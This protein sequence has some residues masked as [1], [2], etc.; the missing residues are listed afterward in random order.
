MNA[1]SIRTP[2]A[3]AIRAML[4]DL[5]DILVDAVE[6][7]AGVSFMAPLDPAEAR[8]FWMSVSDDV[9]AGTK[10]LLVAD[11]DGRPAGTVLLQL[12]WQPNQPHR[13]EV[14]KLL[15]HRRARRLGLARQ[16]MRALEQEARARR[17]TLLV[18]DT[19]SGGAAEQLY[20]ALG[21]TEVGRIP[22]Y[23]LMP[24]GEM[25]DTTYFYRAL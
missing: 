25:S 23:A 24:Y 2:D 17:R 11:H 12:M 13:A 8:A 15:V 5:V 21:W 3:A 1:A 10:V 14:A 4:P 6:G 19:V 18:L 9:A 7:G 22:N 20:R 16:L